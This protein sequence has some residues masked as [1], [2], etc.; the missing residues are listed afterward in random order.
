MTQHNLGNVLRDRSIRTSGESSTRLLAEAVAAYKAAL[1]VRTHEQLPQDWAMTQVSLGTTLWDQGVRA[2]GNESGRLLSDAV[3]AYKAAMTVYTREQLPQQWAMTQ[4]NLGNVVYEQG[5][6]KVDTRLLAEAVAAYKAA[7]TVY[8]RERLPQQWAMTQHNLGSVLCD[9][10]IRTSGEAG[11]RLLV[12]AVLAYRAALTIRTQAQLS[13][14]WAA[15]SSNLVEALFLSG[16]FSEARDQLTKVLQYSDLDPRTKVALLAIE[17][18]NFVAL[19]MP[20]KVQHSL[21]LLEQICGKQMSDF[22]LLWNFIAI[23]LFIDQNQTFA[24]HRSWL[25][26]FLEQ[27][28]GKPRDEMR[29]AATAA[30]HAFLKTIKS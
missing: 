29:D 25:H 13:V 3:A 16:Q 12:E 15:T 6:R 1:T 27:L 23:K 24:K 21:E 17:A 22:S 28:E 10:G 7:L 9:Q 8:T 5:M 19:G 18:A 30:R 2:K 26:S 11:T 14:D 20:G 4:H